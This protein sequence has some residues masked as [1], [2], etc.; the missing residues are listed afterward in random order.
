MEAVEN[1]YHKVIQRVGT[2][3][4]RRVPRLD[5]KGCIGE[6]CRRGSI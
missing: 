6:T 4:Q 2:L 5:R 1:D 3:T